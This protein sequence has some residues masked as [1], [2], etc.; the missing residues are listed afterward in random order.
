M[1]VKSNISTIEGTYK[2]NGAQMTEMS[3][4][5]KTCQSHTTRL[6]TMPK[7]KFSH[8]NNLGSYNKYKGIL[9]CKKSKQH[10]KENVSFMG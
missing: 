9:P 5:R 6:S 8:L 3:Q 2:Q 1:E 10:N 4:I 7:R